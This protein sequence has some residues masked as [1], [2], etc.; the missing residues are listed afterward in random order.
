MKEIDK[1]SPCLTNPDGCVVLMRGSAEVGTG[2][3]VARSPTSLALY[4]AGKTT[5]YPAEGLNI[6]ATIPPQAS[7]ARPKAAG[8]PT[9]E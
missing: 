8:V 9:H 4:E 7:Q 2:R 1:A 5:I 6:T 3:F